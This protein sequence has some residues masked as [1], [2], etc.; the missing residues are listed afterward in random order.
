M[1]MRTMASVTR[2]YSACTTGYR[3]LPV[4]ADGTPVAD[5]FCQEVV[6]LPI[7]PYLGAA[8]RQRAV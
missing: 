8:G 3:R 5:R 4:V 7:H 2:S 1:A 6:S